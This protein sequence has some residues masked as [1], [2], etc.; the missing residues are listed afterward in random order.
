MREP[1]PRRSEANAAK[2]KKGT[3]N[4]E[5]STRKKARRATGEAQEA[6]EQS[7]STH[8]KSKLTHPSHQHELHILPNFYLWHYFEMAS[9]S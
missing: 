5:E 9:L 8:R 1:D 3:P 2:Q 6:H 7:R 4:R